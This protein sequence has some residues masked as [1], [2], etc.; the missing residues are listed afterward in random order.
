MES[1][2]LNIK[3]TFDGRLKRGVLVSSSDGRHSDA[4]VFFYEGSVEYL[5]EG[6]SF[7]AAAGSV[8]YLPR[9]SVYEMHVFEPARYCCI[10]FDFESSERLRRAELFSGL[11][12]SVANDFEKLFYASYRAESWC[13]AESFSTLYKIYAAL[14]RSKV[15]KYTRSGKLAADAVNYILERYTDPELTISEIS[16]YLGI[17]DT[18]LRRVFKEKTGVAPVHYINH[19]RFEKAKHMMKNSNCT[20]KEIAA[21]VGF[22]DQYYFSREFKNTFG[23]S[24]SE[25]IKKHGITLA[26]EI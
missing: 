11:P 21:L 17:S 26:K 18:H 15:K 4:F 13:Y 9:S 12:L 1:K 20:I 16:C 2:I 14:L 3:K 6:Y 24:P 10:D 8:V 5:F 19:I 7:L 23:I 25:Y 22:S